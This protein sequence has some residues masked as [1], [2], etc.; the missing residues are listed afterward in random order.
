[1]LRPE[2]GGQRGSVSYAGPRGAFAGIPRSE[3]RS[4]WAGRAAELVRIETDA[5]IV[6]VKLEREARGSCSVDAA[7]AAHLEPSRA[8]ALVCCAR[9]GGSALPVECYDNGLKHRVH[10]ALETADEV[11]APDAEPGCTRGARRAQTSA[12][13]RPTQTGWKTR[14][15]APGSA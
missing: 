12:R 6:P 4:C 9:C 2:R 15:F 13:L 11:C 7:A 5:A 8:S 3:R 14:M 10:V 1:V